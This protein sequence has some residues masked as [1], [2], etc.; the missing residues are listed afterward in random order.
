MIDHKNG[1]HVVDGKMCTCSLDNQPNRDIVA[2]LNRA[3]EAERDAERYLTALEAVRRQ[4]QLLMEDMDTLNEYPWGHQWTY[5][6]TAMIAGGA[7][8][9]G[10][11][12]GQWLFS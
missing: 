6:F 7:A 2:C 8:I 3:Y 1:C 11:I 12:V 4:N 10:L 9:V 5:W